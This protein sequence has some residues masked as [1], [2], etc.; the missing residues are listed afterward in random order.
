M[1]YI[2]RAEYYVFVYKMRAHQGHGAMKISLENV[3]CK[4]DKMFFYI[5]IMIVGFFH[6][7]YSNRSST[8]PVEGRFNYT[9]L[10]LSPNGCTLI[11]VNEGKM[12]L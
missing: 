8:L 12:N 10:D 7:C 11:A 9:A 6:F 2:S 5:T 3:C 1:D 4:M